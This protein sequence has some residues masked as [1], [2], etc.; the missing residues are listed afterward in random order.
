MSD[1]QI[2][3]LLVLPLYKQLHAFAKDPSQWGLPESKVVHVFTDGPCVN[4]NDGVA[5]RAGFSIV[6]DLSDDNTTRAN[7][8]KEFA[9]T[10]KVPDVFRVHTIAHV[11][12]NQTAAR[13]ELSA[14]AHFLQSIETYNLDDIQ[15]VFHSDASYVLGVIDRICCDDIPKSHRTTNFDLWQIIDRLWNKETYEIQKV[16]AHEKILPYD[17]MWEAW[18]KLENH[19]ADEA[20]KTSLKHEIPDVIQCANNVAEFHR[21]QKS[22]MIKVLSY[23]ADFNKQSIADHNLLD[24]QNKQT[25]QMSQKVSNSRNIR[26]IMETGHVENYRHFAWPDLEISS[27]KCCSWGQKTAFCVYAWAKTLRWPD[28]IEPRQINDVGISYL[29]LFANFLLVTGVTLPITIK[30]VGSKIHW[31]YFD[32]PRA[33]IQPKRTRS[34]IVQ[35]V[36]LDTVVMQLE[37][38]LNQKFFFVPKQIGVKTLS[39]LGHTQLQKR[40]GYIR[41]PEMKFG[42]ETLLLVDKFLHECR[43]QNNWNLPLI[44]KRYLESVPVPIALDIPDGITE[45]TP[46]AVEYHKK[47]CLKI[48]A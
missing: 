13:G 22:K 8:L 33:Y 5:R 25:D 6:V 28:V 11:S 30:R 18:K 29:E 35:S 31:E 20:A 45:L 40:T 21:A 42:K 7:Q 38:I 36:V 47:R 27:A 9:L 24:A 32:S 26:V 46:A 19:I 15:W 23:L 1:V 16:K 37:K 44:P 3:P 48:R 10:G 41:R 39:H 2:C 12:G 17:D 34:A 14:V 4:S 43:E